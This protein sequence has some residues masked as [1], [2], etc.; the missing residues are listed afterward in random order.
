MPAEVVTKLV[1]DLA[2][3][4]RLW[5]R[6][7][8]LMFAIDPPASEAARDKTEK[9]RALA[10]DLAATFLRAALDHVRAW[11]TLVHAGEVP[12]FAQF[13]LLRTAHESALTAY[14]LCEPG[15]TPDERRARGIAAQLADY[16]ERRK[17]EI[18][19]GMPAPQPPA[20]TAK[21]RYDELFAAAREY[22][23]TRTNAKD[24]EV[25]ATPMPSAV[26]L[27]RRYEHAGPG[28]EASFMYRWYSGYAHGKQWALTQGGERVTPFDDTGR[29]LAR[30]VANDDM[31]LVVTRWT[32]LAVDRAFAAFTALH[33]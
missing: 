25:L 28:V 15:I 14:W 17:F 26:D 16:D 5:A 8:T 4:D 32:L 24:K 30:I 33:T 10:Y 20:R 19:A 12:I 29:S 6:L 3:V 18:D 2:H 11:R 23:L 31:L 9:H 27:F 21:E 13:S 7:D 22:G 1:A